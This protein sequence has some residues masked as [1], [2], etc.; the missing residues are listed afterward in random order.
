M[1]EGTIKD[2]LSGLS[3]AAKKEVLDRLVASLLSDLSE[4]EQRAMLQKVLAADKENR[5]LS[6]MVEH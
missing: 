4:E 5:Q 1:S 3:H 6:S 2:M